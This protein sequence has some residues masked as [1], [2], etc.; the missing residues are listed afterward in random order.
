MQDFKL[1]ECVIKAV[2]F[3]FICS[4]G[5]ERYERMRS[6]TQ[7]LYPLIFITPR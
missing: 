4:R 7:N 1:S 3:R 2:N 6:T 5:T